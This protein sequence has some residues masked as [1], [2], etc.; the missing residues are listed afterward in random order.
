MAFEE[1]GVTSVEN[2]NTGDL[3][4]DFALLQNYPNPFNPTTRIEFSLPVESNVK[5]IIYNLLGQEVIRLADEQM[6]AG[7]HKFDWNANDG[8]GNKLTSGIYFY[9][10][11]ATG[12]NGN[13]FQEIK[14]MAFVEIIS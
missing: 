12:I 3:P 8:N 10:L 5:L 6:Q 13:E 11:S 4:S 14:K 2:E 7:N 9:K 1:T